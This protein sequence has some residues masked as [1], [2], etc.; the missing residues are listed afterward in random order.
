M[1]LNLLHQYFETQQ[2]DK[3]HELILLQKES[4]KMVWMGWY[5]LHKDGL[6]AGEQYCLLQLRN[7]SANSGL[8]AVLGWIYWEQ[9]QPIKGLSTYKK[10]LTLDWSIPA[11][12]NAVSIGCEIGDF[13]SV[14]DLFEH[15]EEQLDLNVLSKHD[16]GNYFLCK[17]IVARE[18]GQ[19][20]EALQL[21]NSIENQVPEIHILRGHIYRDEF[22]YTQSLM[23][24]QE[25]LDQFPMH[26]VLFDSFQNVLRYLPSVPK[27]IHAL[28]ADKPNSVAAFMKVRSYLERIQ[29]DLLARDEESP[30]VQ[31][32][33]AAI[34]G[35]NPPKPPVGYVEELFDDYAE[36]FESHLIERLQYQVPRLIESV[37]YNRFTTEDLADS[38]WDLGCGTGL[39]G[40]QLRSVSNRLVGVDLSGNMLQRAMEKNCYDTLVHDDIITFLASH[41]ETIFPDLIIVADTLVYLGDLRPFFTAVSLCMQS[42]T[43]LICTLEQLT[44]TND[45]GF[46]LMPTG[47]Y[48]HSI[49]WIEWLLPQYG[50]SLEKRGE[51]V[52]RQGGGA[53]VHGWL[54]VIEVIVDNPL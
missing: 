24:Y 26:P 14:L 16:I 1:S 47:R 43:Q 53:W 41:T 5:I 49:E 36:R 31:H 50:L 54:L 8:W 46:Q 37:V 48:S 6:Q 42:G 39:L 2:F 27:G 44:E 15:Y 52:L 7:Y 28:L 19:S 4:L 9:N 51:V 40:T 18:T 30:E 38:I 33:S 11:Y 34:H 23:A 13:D 17:A 45:E 29:A 32:L 12:L 25:G 21:L 10:S 22:L 3:A 35:K 20:T